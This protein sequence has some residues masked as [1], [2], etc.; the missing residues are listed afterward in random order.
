[1]R[2]H[3]KPVCI[4][5]AYSKPCCFICATRGPGQA[6]D[7]GGKALRVVGSDQNSWMY[8]RSIS[9]RVSL[10]AASMLRMESSLRSEGR[11][12]SEISGSS[13]EGH[14]ALDDVF[15][16]AYVAWKRIAGEDIQDLQGY[17]FHPP[18]RRLGCI[19]KKWRISRGMS[20]GRAR[21]GGNG[22]IT[23]LSR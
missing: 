13:E 14:G 4:Q 18:C 7:L 22:I 16:F 8:F 17:V 3:Y 23:T 20:S 11:S 19:F 6:E 15:Q 21:S 12:R 5:G 2:G 9:S 1:M 10:G